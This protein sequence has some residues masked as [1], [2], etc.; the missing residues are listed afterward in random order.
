MKHLLLFI[1]ISITLVGF[2]TTSSCRTA[3]EPLSDSQLQS[4]PLNLEFTDCLAWELH[5]A[6]TM[7]YLLDHGR[8][9][10]VFRGRAE[11]R[12]TRDV[13]TASMARNII[14]AIIKKEGGRCSKE[15]LYGEPCLLHHR[16]Y[17]LQENYP[18]TPHFLPFEYFSKLTGEVMNH[19][20]AQQLSS[21]WNHYE[22]K[23][24]Q[25]L[26]YPRGIG[27]VVV[28]ISHEEENPPTGFRYRF[29][30]NL[31]MCLLKKHSAYLKERGLFDF[32]EL[33]TTHYLFKGFDEVSL[34]LFV[35]RTN[36]KATHTEKST[37]LQTLPSYE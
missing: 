27:G 14:Q 31:G 12:S 9:N 37:A 6:G 19:K 8:H 29:H 16:D 11:A 30:N 21:A 3:P 2:L 15:L 28:E 7:L 24:F 26:P 32:S 25:E 35:K 34:E 10:V 18:I 17:G 1:S 36:Q 13:I 33:F 23:V 5:L 20:R 22:D 4:Q